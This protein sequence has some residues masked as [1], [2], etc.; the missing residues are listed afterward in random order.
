M[1]ALDILAHRIIK[2]EKFNDFQAVLDFYYVT[3]I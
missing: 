1:D 2:I 3:I